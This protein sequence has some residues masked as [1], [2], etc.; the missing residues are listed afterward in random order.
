MAARK[1]E[2]EERGIHKGDGQEGDTQGLWISRL[3]KMSQEEV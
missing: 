1:G 3:Y 2:G